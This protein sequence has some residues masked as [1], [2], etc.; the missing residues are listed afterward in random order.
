MVGEA[1][2]TEKRLQSQCKR[3]RA[4]VPSHQVTELDLPF[5]SLSPILL[6][7]KP[8]RQKSNTDMSLEL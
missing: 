7:A 3:N 6:S 2:G 5:L 1:W 8:R 4:A